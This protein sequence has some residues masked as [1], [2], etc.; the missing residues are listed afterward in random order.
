MRKVFCGCAVALMVTSVAYAGKTLSSPV[1]VH[2]NADNSGSMTG[3][4]GSTRNS[5]DTTSY[6][7]CSTDRYG[8]G[9]PQMHC[10]A[11]TAAGVG[12]YC[13]SSSAQLVTAIDSMPNDAYIV[14]S[15]DATA[16]CTGISVYHDSRDEPKQ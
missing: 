3:S 9:S 16:T 14:V 2:R 10:S 8:T 1:T 13:H 7:S 11:T 4:L 12:G 5:A 6:L 15:W